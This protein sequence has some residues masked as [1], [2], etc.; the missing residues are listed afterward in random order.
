MVEALTAVGFLVIGWVSSAASTQSDPDFRFT[1]R[2]ALFVVLLVLATVPYA[3][4]RRWATPAFLVSLAATTA[5]WLLGYNAGALPLLLLVG[6]TFVAMARPDREVVAC[7]A[8]ACTCFALLWW[9]GGAPFGSREAVASVLALGVALGLGRG[10]QL[11]VDLAEA[12][13]RAAYEAAMRTASEERLH[14]SRELHDIVGHSLGIIA[15]QAG[16]GR[17]LIDSEPRR[18]AEALDNIAR[19][20]RDALGEVRA[21]VSTLRDGRPS[22]HPAPGLDDLPALVETARLAGIAVELT[23]PEDVASISRQTGMAVH[24]ITREALTNVVRHA[25]AT[26]ATVRVDHHDGVVDLT[27]RDNGSVGAT[28]TLTPHVTSHGFAG[29]RERVEALGGSV[30]AGPCDDGGFLVRATLPIDGRPR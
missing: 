4:R 12:R 19:V 26:A 28:A 14:V 20:S 24:R 27:V 5:L 25:R 13:A 11:R 23:L 15:V 29:M 8:A 2:D 6:G 16:V 18:A 17:H 22:Y 9:G 3:W 7:A 1:P 30:S 21:V 10:A